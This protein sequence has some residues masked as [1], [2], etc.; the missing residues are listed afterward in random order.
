M[1]RSI[2][3][4]LFDAGGIAWAMLSEAITISDA[5]QLQQQVETLRNALT[6]TASYLAIVGTAAG[7]LTLLLALKAIYDWFYSDTDRKAIENLRHQVNESATR[8]NATAGF[9]N[10][11]LETTATATRRAIEAQR[12]FIDFQVGQIDEKCIEVIRDTTGYDKSIVAV[13]KKS[14]LV[15]EYSQTIRALLPLA[16]FNYSEVGKV[17]GGGSRRL[18]M[19]AACYY[20]L[21]FDHHMQQNFDQAIRYWRLSR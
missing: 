19:P 12:G 9:V 10:D 11:I 15:R 18:P 5:Q 4:A 8:A 2:S 21:S 3:D 7:V 14:A 1:I 6:F 16:E 17:S 13:S 20:I